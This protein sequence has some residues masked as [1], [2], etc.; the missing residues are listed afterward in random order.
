M[1][2]LNFYLSNNDMERLFYI[3]NKLENKNDLTGNEFA[4]ELLQRE[5]HR[6]SPSIPKTDKNGEYI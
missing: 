4:K 2:E 1:A 3:K 6:L 5:L